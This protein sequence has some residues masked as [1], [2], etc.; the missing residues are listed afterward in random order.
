MYVVASPAHHQNKITANRCAEWQESQGSHLLFGVEGG[1][2]FSFGKGDA[3][4]VTVIEC[5]HAIPC[6][7]FAID[8][9]RKRLKQEYVSDLFLIFC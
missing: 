7:G 8:E 5:I 3:Y 1:D 4:Q 9:K 2:K 6:V